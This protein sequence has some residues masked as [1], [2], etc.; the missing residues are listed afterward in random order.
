MTRQEEIQKR[1]NEIDDNIDN[2]STEA[3]KWNVYQMGMKIKN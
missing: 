3:D 2:L 1:L